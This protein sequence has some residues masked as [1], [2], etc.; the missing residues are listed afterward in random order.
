MCLPRSG[1]LPVWGGAIRLYTLVRQTDRRL[2]NLLRARLLQLV[3]GIGRTT[4]H[5]V[6]ASGAP[7][8]TSNE[9]STRS[10]DF[11]APKIATM[12]YRGPKC[13]DFTFYQAKS[14]DLQG[15]QSQDQLWEHFVSMGQFEGRNFRWASML[16]TFP[17]MCTV[18]L[19]AA[20]LSCHGCRF[21]CPLEV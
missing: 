1:G 4:V 11:K 19:C 6:Q 17:C 20:R 18:W 14:K 13:F 8:V 16:A 21:T 5:P 10:Q 7:D 15:L 2:A 12:R 3:E 9:W